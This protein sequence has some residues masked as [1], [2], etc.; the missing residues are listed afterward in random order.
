MSYPK[1]HPHFAHKFCRLLTKSAAALEIGPEVC[2][3]LT[4]IV[5][6]EDA[7]RYR[8]AANYWNHQLMGVVGVSSVG[9]LDRIR[10]AA[11]NAGWLHYEPGG[12]SKIGVYWVKIPTA[13]EGI[14]DGASDESP[15]DFSTR[16]QS[17]N[18]TTN[19]HTTGRKPSRETGDNRE[20]TGRETGCKPST[21]YPNPFPIP[22]DPGAGTGFLNVEWWKGFEDSDLKDDSKLDVLFG[23]VVA[24]GYAHDTAEDRQRF[25]ALVIYAR[26]QEAKKPF[27]LF[28]RIVDGKSKSKFAKRAD[29]RSRAT[30]ADHDAS[31]KLLR[32][33][34]AEDVS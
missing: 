32:K 2:W 8:G 15:A 6:Q 34:D 14:E 30:D 19:G 22:K 31:R 23:A 27:G 12:K 4:V 17:Q 1:R 11:V 7:K 26:R 24:A 9:R 18:A 13:A 10:E 20:T 29:W 28:T 16:L 21:S 33:L 3:L 5:H 25:T